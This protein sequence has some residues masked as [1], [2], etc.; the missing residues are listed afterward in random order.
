MNKSTL[1]PI[2]KHVRKRVERCFSSSRPP[3]VIGVSGG[4]DSMALLH[5]FWRLSIPVTVGHINYEQ[6]GEASEQD[7][8]LVEDFTRDRNISCY[9]HRPGSFPGEGE[10]FQEWARKRRFSFL[11]EL[12]NRQR[13]DA[14]ALAHHREDQVETLLQKLFRGAGPGGWS[15][16]S[17]FSRPF[18]RPLL[19]VPEHKI[20]TYMESWNIPYRIDESNLR[21][22]Y[23][24]NFLRNEWIPALEEHFPGWRENILDL[25]GKSKIFTSVV[26][27][28]LDQAALAEDKLNRNEVLAWDLPVQK[29]V[30]LRWIKDNAP[31]L[32]VSAGALDE[33]EKLAGLQTGQSLHITGTG[34]I[35]RDRD[36]LVWVTEERG[37]R[38]QE[39]FLLQREKLMSDSKYRQDF[40]FTLTAPDDPE[41][42][43]KLVLDEDALQWPVTVRRWKNGDR[44]QPFGMEG[45]QK[46]KDHLTNRKVPSARKKSALVLEDNRSRIVAVLFPPEV[47]REEPGTIADFVK[48][49]ANTNKALEIKR[50]GSDS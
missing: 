5:I 10:N 32:S 14:I 33:L 30:I 34:K 36:A 26:R 41:N 29:A 3:L 48:C 16:M 9:T 7:Q 15:G 12:M 8:Q 20:E 19:E 38:N 18:F 35:L 42:P 2:E 50:A 11:K 25:P 21:S 28:L 45:R 1:Q 17:V 13:A 44:F 47:P 40:E 4:P 27:T 37:N 39:Q 49:D 22:K 31:D 46:V 24:R 43:A 6:R 23:A